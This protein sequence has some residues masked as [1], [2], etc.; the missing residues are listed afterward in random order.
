MQ[1]IDMSL[2][3]ILV[4]EIYERAQQDCSFVQINLNTSIDRIPSRFVL[5]RM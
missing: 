2:G 1:I 5:A 4:V 3:S